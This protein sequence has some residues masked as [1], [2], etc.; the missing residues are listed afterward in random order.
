[1][2]NTNAPRGFKPVGHMAG[3]TV[4]ARE[5]TIA[6]EYAANIFTGDPVQ[7]TGTGRNIAVATAQTADSIGVFAGCAY[8]DAAG[9]RKFSHYWPTGTVATNIVAYVYD[10]PDIIY[11]IQADTVAAADIGLLADWNDTAGSAVTGQSGRSLVASAANTANLACRI[12]GLARQ[13]D[14]AY[15]AYGKVL[16]HFAEHAY[17]NVVAGVGGVS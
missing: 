17:S 6:S 11:E 8:T 4:R 7:L 9:V 14:N 2:A 16:V 12:L 1:M 10:D 15:G 5:Y 13:P 3:G